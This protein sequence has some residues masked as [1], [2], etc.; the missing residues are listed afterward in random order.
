MVKSVNARKTTMAG[1][2]LR[3][4]IYRRGTIDASLSLSLSLSLL[5]GPNCHL[6][7]SRR[8]D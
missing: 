7:A 6:D 8:E 5:N 4:I 1:G 3:A 2:H